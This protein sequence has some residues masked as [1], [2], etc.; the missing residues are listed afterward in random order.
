[1]RSDKSIKQH[2]KNREDVRRYWRTKKN[3]NDMV[4]DRDV[5]REY[6][7]VDEFL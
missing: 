3:K 5:E 6:P 1:M 4:K 7:C 2:R